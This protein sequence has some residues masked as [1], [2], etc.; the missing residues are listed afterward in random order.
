[1]GDGAS[2]GAT[3]APSAADKAPKAS[4]ATGDAQKENEGKGLACSTGGGGG[5]GGTGGK[6]AKKPLEFFNELEDSPMF[7]QQAVDLEQGA[8]RFSPISHSLG[9]SS[10]TLVN[11]SFS[12]SPLHS[13]WNIDNDRGGEA[14]EAR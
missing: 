11:R 5:R 4:S 7:K 6:V 8:F 10:L 13:C 12:F 9:R 3:E 2:D 1:M 14:E